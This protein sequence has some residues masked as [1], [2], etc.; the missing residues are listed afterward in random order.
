MSACNY[1]NDDSIDST[2]M[3]DS[4][5]NSDDDSVDS[6]YDVEEN[7]SFIHSLIKELVDDPEN[8]SMDTKEIYK[9]LIEECKEKY[10]DMKDA[11]EDELWKCLVEKTENFIENN[12]D[13]KISHQAAFERSI[14]KYKCVIMEYIKDIMDEEEDVNYQD[15]EKI[16]VEEDI[17]QTGSGYIRS[18]SKRY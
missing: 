16:S 9:K 3:S 4:N 13:L 8:N 7:H 11:E 14:K 10:Q 15:K 18:F 12:K 5:Y 2:Y 17:G 1:K 6:T